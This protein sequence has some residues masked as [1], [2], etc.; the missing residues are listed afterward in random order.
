MPHLLAGQPRLMN[1]PN[2][3]GLLPAEL[4]L[5]DMRQV[6]TFLAQLT[7]PWKTASERGALASHDV[8]I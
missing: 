8:I 1:V 2:A 3:V 7:A 5:N 4:M 6:F